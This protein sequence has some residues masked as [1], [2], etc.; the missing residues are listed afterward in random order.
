MSRFAVRD[1]IDQLDPIAD[2]QRIVYLSSQYDFGFSN[3]RALEF[4]LF[5]TYAAPRMTAILDQA[6]EFYR[7]PQKRYDDTA[8]IISEIV[9]HGY[10]SERGRA[11]I[12][13][14]N[15][16][17][18]HFPIENEDF[19]YTL[20]VFFLEPIRWN[21]LLGWRRYTVKE[22]LAYFH[23]WRE[24]GRRMNIKDIPDTFDAFER[25]SLDYERR[26][27][28]YAETNRRIADST[29]SV[30]EGWLPGV[31]R[32]LI[33]PVVVALL[34]DLTREGF[35]YA[36]QPRLLTLMLKGAFRLRAHI[37][38]LLPPNRQPYHWTRQ[39]NRTYPH[40]Y[41]VTRLGHAPG[42]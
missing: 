16:I 30:F 1:Q 9:E 29:M 11:A 20:S 24:V 17:H 10:D 39:P 14:M 4:A 32:P 40:G 42:E 19:L 12:K 3:Q 38:R 22:K 34:D 5:K 21:E 13:R 6:G 18:R 36:K 37:I 27:F 8:L 28:R 41:D 2:H 23:F 33:K 31:M 35:G 26:Y 7:R 15:R 25:F